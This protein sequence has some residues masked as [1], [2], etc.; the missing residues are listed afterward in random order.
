MKNG[1]K[2][3][4][5]VLVLGAIKGEKT[6]FI[7]D[8]AKKFHPEGYN[9][10][11]IIGASFYTT[12]ITVNNLDYI[13]HLW[14]L[15]DDDK[16]L[17]LQYQYYR[18]AVAAILVVDPTENRSVKKVSKQ[19]ESLKKIL[20]RNIPILIVEYD[21]DKKMA[22]IEKPLREELKML[23]TDEGG[24]Y[25][26]YKSVNKQEID[27]KL[28]ELIQKMNEILLLN[29]LLSYVNL[30]IILLL[31]IFKELGMKDIA[32]YL[33][34][35]KSTIS[36][37]TRQ[38]KELGVIESHEKSDESTPGSIPKN[39]YAISND[40]K[41]NSKSDTTILHKIYKYILLSRICDYLKA[42]S[43]KVPSGIL[44]LLNVPSIQPGLSRKER[45][46]DRIRRQF[47]NTSLGLY[48]MSENQLQ[49]VNQLKEEFTSKLREIL[50]KEDVNEKEYV[51]M[52]IHF[53]L[54]QLIESVSKIKE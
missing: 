8:F 21:L 14:I 11:K 3:P 2:T 51:Y 38:L 24:V 41:L 16:F 20:R 29:L 13:L 6:I 48:F 4:L 31:S 5:K 26:E 44:S 27:K 10:Q 9:T 47:S 28:T 36:R 7:N 34:K 42:F 22:A 43:E 17:S 25:L 53:P 49:K 12:E 45:A 1:S 23:A 30:D 15:S 33:K 54:F 32:D 18:G 50:Q 46:Y 39:Y 35:S 52:D 37:S 40:F 19:I